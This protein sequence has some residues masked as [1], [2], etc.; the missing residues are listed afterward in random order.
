MIGKTISHHKTIVKIRSGG[1]GS[2]QRNI[3][4]KYYKIVLG[5]ILGEYN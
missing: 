4:M 5:C 3:I 2:A 1:M